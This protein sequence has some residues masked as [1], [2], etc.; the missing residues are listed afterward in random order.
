MV[1]EV[2]EAKQ[3]LCSLASGLVFL[4]FAHWVGRPYVEVVTMVLI[5]SYG[6]YP[7]KDVTLQ[8]KS[9]SHHP[10]QRCLYKD[11]VS[12]TWSYNCF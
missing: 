4:G 9:G 7:D 5:V 2:R 6:D 8:T 11:I 1:R 3:L 10:P 12:R